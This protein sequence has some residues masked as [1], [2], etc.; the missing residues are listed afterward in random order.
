MPRGLNTKLGVQ[1][2]AKAKHFVFGLLLTTLKVG[3]QEQ[4]FFF[5]WSCMELQA[6]SLE[7][8]SMAHANFLV[9]FLVGSF[10]LSKPR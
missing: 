1:N 5:F 4:N 9:N 6:Q 3:G 2:M 10:L 7:V 8:Q